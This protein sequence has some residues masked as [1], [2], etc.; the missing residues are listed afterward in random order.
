SDRP[1]DKL[2]NMKPILFVRADPFETFGVAPGA[3][4]SAGGEV[5]VWEAISNEPAP[6]LSGCAGIVTF[7]STY[8]V[9]HADEQPF[10]SQIGALARD[11]V[12][13]GV[14]F[15]GSCFGAQLLAWTLGAE[16]KKSDVREVGFEPIRPLEAAKEDRLTAHLRDADSA[17]HE[18]RGAEIF[19][20]FVEV[21]R[22]TAV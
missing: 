19:R 2:P 6:P 1:V 20:R 13:A 17:E 22:E 4:A 15:L 21:C 9:E 10:I 5:L 12:S 7:G 11:A 14:P 16:V 3:V 8:N 18:R